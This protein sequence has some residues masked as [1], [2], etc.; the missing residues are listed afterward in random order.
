MARHRPPRRRERA[1]HPPT[2]APTGSTAPDPTPPARH[3]L[4]PPPD[5][6][7]AAQYPSPMSGLH[8]V[9]FKRDL[10][11]TDH[12]PLLRAAAAGPTLPL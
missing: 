2:S 6:A 10:R 5:A 11:V 3:S 9:W 12:R 1:L 4:P 8:V 7:P